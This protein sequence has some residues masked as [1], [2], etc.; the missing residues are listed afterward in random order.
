MRKI[1]ILVSLFLCGCG[2]YRESYVDNQDGINHTVE[3]DG[4]IPDVRSRYEPNCVLYWQ[5][6]P[7]QYYYAPVPPYGGS[8]VHV[9]SR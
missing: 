8:Y 9:W 2:T 4:F 1:S 6:S 7:P 5:S 3:Y